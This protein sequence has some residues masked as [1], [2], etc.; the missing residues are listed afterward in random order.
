MGTAK[1]ALELHAGNA[2]EVVQVLRPISRFEPSPRSL[3]GIYLPG[4]AYLQ[5]RM[6]TEAVAE[7]QKIVSHRGMAARSS[8]FPLAYLGMGRG[9]VVAGDMANARM[10]YEEFLEIW[11]N[12]DADI[13]ILVQ[14][15]AEYAGLKK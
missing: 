11:K 14:A 2:S 9:Y 6:G 15:R 12:A 10:G 4:Q 7:F 5:L 13:P 3:L 1:A 8:L